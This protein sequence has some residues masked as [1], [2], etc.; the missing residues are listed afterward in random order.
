MVQTPVSRRGTI[1]PR[2]ATNPAAAA[3]RGRG[4]RRSSRYRTCRPSCDGK[5]CRAR[6]VRRR[7]VRLDAD[8]R[9]PIPSP[10]RTLSSS[11]TRSGLCLS[12]GA[13]DAPASGALPEVSSAIVYPHCSL[14]F[15]EP[16]RTR[17][18]C[19]LPASLNPAWG[20]AQPAIRGST[21]RRWPERLRQLQ[22]EQHEQEQ[23]PEV[24]EQP[25][26]PHSAFCGFRAM[27]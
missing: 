3:R 17:T 18:R 6:Q 14:R 10:V 12:W 11:R 20:A 27:P 8:H 25:L 7:G 13:A 4:W 22:L 19:V 5:T 23:A 2:S 15:T 26:V 1:L 9:R 24:P 16:L 21:L